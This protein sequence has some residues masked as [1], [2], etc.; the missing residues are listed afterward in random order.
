M[1]LKFLHGNLANSASRSVTTSL[2]LAS[3]G[4]CTCRCVSSPGVM[5]MLL[6]NGCEVVVVTICIMVEFVDLVVGFG[7]YSSYLHEWS[8]TVGVQRLPR[9]LPPPTLLLINGAKLL[10]RCFSSPNSA[11][12]VLP[13]AAFRFHTP[14]LGSLFWLKLGFLRVAVCRC[15]SP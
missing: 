9:G 8:A 7:G 2:R 3:C 15:I 4:G 5:S 11:A 14:W 10:F 6:H 12:W 1:T 13:L